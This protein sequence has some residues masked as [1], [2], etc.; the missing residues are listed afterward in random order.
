V[1]P[2]RTSPRGKDRHRLADLAFHPSRI[3]I[4]LG[5]ILVL[6][7]MSLSFVGGAGIRRDSIQADALP[8]LLLVLLAF[9][10]SLLPDRRTPVRSLQ[11]WLALAGATTAFA[12]SVV[13]ELDAVAQASSLGSGPGAGGLLLIFGTLVAAAGATLG[14]VWERAGWP[15]AGPPTVTSDSPRGPASQA[16][17]LPPEPRLRRPVTTATPSRHAEPP[18][19]PADIPSG[20][21]RRAPAQAPNRRRRDPP[22]AP[23]AA[24]PERPPAPGQWWPEDLDDLFR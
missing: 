13:V 7:A 3:A 2:G 20:S 21:S 18:R 17:R 24:P 23:P 8:S 14:L 22:P 12:Y 15:M 10:I 16:G 5:L 4:G 6:G 11:A 19:P 9:A 1:I